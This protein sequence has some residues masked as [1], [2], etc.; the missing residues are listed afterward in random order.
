MI[1]KAKEMVKLT[2]VILVGILA[3]NI[4]YDVGVSNSTKKQ[5]EVVRIE[6]LDK[7]KA[8][9]E[10]EG[11]S[12]APKPAAIVELES[13]KSKAIKYASI[14]GILILAVAMLIILSNKEDEE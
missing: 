10:A 9:A 3:F 1:K 5:E 8:I 4:A 13:N 12:S 2:I 11:A 14:I 7:V 6:D